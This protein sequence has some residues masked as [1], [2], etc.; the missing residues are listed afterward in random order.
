MLVQGAAIAAGLCTTVRADELD[1]SAGV[2]SHTILRGVVLGETTVRAAASYTTAGGWLAGV[3]VA[4][5]RAEAGDAWDPQLSLKAGYA[6]LL[7]ADWAWQWSYTHHAYPGS[8]RLATYAHDE[9][10][11][12]LAFRDQ[13]YMSIA[14][15]R[16]RRAAA[17]EG[18]TS[19]AY[20]LVASYPL[21][22][23]VA[24]NVGVGYRDRRRFS[25]AYGHAGLG[26]RWGNTQADVSYIATDSAAK[27]R[28]GTAAANRWIGSVMWRF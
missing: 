5:L 19:V 28:L 9:L 11:T 24:A 27:N 1:L 20:E 23:Q 6:R 2:A 16:N 12:T 7:R 21:Q 10:A 8:S 17:S 13:V 25:Y 22:P 15:L 14:G 26:V 18:R 3:N 4:G